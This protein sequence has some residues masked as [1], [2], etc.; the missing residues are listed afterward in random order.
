MKAP[1][2]PNEAQR[3]KALRSYDVLDTPPDASLDDLTRLAAQ[4]CET[5]IALISL[6]DE[7]RQWFK[8]RVG[9]DVSET[10]RELSF[11]SHTILETGVVLEVNDAR[12]DARFADNALVISDPNIQFYAGASLITHDGH[13]LGTICVIDRTPRQLT[14]A[15]TAALRVLS[16]LVVTQLELH[17]RGIELKAEAGK[18]ELAEA[19]LRQ[20]EEEKDRLLALGEKS[21]LALLSVLEDE[22][23]TGRDL[24][25][26]EERFRQLA[27]NIQEVF[28]INDPASGR[29]LYVS[30]AYEKI[31]GRTCASLYESPRT[32][33]DAVHP[34]DRERVMHALETRLTSGE[35][36][37][38]Y[39]I[40]RADGTVHWI[41][42][43]GFPVLD[44]SGEVTRVVGTAE[45][46]TEQRHL[47]TQFRQSQKMEAIG[48]LAGGVAHDFNNILAAIMMQAE[49]ALTVT[50]PPPETRELIEDIKA[51]TDRA[52]N[53]T[54]QLLAFSRRQVI[55]P[56]QLDLNEIVTSLTNMLQRIVGED[57]H[58][59]LNL[60]S[61]PLITRADSGMLDQVL[62]NLVVNARD[63][64]PGGGRL[65]INTGEKTFSEEEASSIPDASAGRH[66]WLSVA[67]TGCGI[68]PEC[69]ARIFE[70]FFTTKDP[71][72]GTGLG[73]AT[74]FGIIKQHGGAISLESK[75]G[76]GTTFQIFLRATD[77]AR[78]EVEAPAERPKPRGGTETIL[79]V[80]DERAV[81]RLTRVVLERVGY[82]VLEASHGVE[83]M[84]V[85]DKHHASI[86]LLFTDMVM[87]NGISGRELASLMHA[88]NPGLR[89]IFTSGYTPEMAGK[90]LSLK[91]GQ[92][93]IQ[94]P[95]TPAL[96]L[97]TVRRCLD[98]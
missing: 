83:A 92:N 75:V 29:V 82:N 26:T 66:V 49:L 17:R 20:T 4:L 74:V 25:A 93:F 79:L 95:T 38:T 40:L 43:R 15:Q 62:L 51:A 70:P 90:E 36:D 12:N 52:A 47:E 61:R 81:R 56:R 1:L 69:M 98:V 23:Q 54:R 37:E 80:E 84:E 60:H 19:L 85:W 97:E 28:W 27:E 2:P 14:A 30:P 42:D 10:P 21:R 41:H 48:Q 96:L 6:I 31:W 89:V 18:R 55:Q 67:D 77:A 59:Q 58:L 7:T 11:C 46:I 50:N 63:A 22:Q 57:V 94:K 39:R 44:E 9:L 13:A 76:T 64:M 32:W 72:K 78:L 87:P 34:D 86:D 33:L 71:G 5:P 53:L 45:D 8:S 68:P 65:F 24:R 88:R 35:Y 3:L 91:E 73:L 16:R